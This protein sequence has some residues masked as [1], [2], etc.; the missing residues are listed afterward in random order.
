MSEWQGNAEAVEKLICA[1]PMYMVPRLEEEENGFCLFYSFHVNASHWQD[2]NYIYPSAH[3][4]ICKL[5]FSVSST[6]NTGQSRRE[7]GEWML[8]V[9]WNKTRL[10]NIQPSKHFFIESKCFPQLSLYWP[11]LSLGLCLLNLNSPCL[12]FYW[13]QQRRICLFLAPIFETV[14]SSINGEVS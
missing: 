4:G 9:E 8:T 14:G 5:Q 1:K 11:L 10:T 12:V 7:E 6:C 2:V 3:R 13:V